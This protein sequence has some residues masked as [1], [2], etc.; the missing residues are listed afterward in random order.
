MGY[1]RNSQWA[2]ARGKA[3]EKIRYAEALHTT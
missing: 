1:V 3:T 2:I